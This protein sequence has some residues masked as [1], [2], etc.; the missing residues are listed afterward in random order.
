MSS[1][2]AIG[3]PTEQRSCRILNKPTPVVMV[4]RGRL[5]INGRRRFPGS[6]PGRPRRPY[7]TGRRTPHP[8]TPLDA[9]RGVRCAGPACGPT[10]PPVA[11]SSPWR[12]CPQEHRELR[13]EGLRFLSPRVS[14]HD[15]APHPEMGGWGGASCVRR[16]EPHRR[17]SPPA[18][19]PRL[20]Q[21]PVAGGR[22]RAA[23]PLPREC[24]A[25]RD[26]HPP[27]AV[28]RVLVM[29]DRPFRRASVSPA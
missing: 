16:L 2:S 12:A 21:C 9:G 13:I 20:A 24:W 28:G 7:G 17:A 5:K 14:S 6:C 15:E 10:A 27:L 1:V 22:K 3:D 11:G 8:A 25:G 19:A 29:R 18:M 4:R 23:A 26:E